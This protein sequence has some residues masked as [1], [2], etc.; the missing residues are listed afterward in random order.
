MV[1]INEYLLCEVLEIEEWYYG[2]IVILFIKRSGYGEFY[3][4]LKKKFITI[5]K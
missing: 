1:I 4:F 2:I 5:Q 3:F